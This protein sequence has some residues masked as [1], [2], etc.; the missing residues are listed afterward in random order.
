MP[1]TDSFDLLRELA[2]PD[3][4]VNQKIKVLNPIF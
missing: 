4:S 3:M 2:I 1:R